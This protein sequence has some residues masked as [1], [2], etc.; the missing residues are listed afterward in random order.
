VSI[1]SLLAPLV[2]QHTALC[3]RC[4]AELSGTSHLDVHRTVM[5]MVRSGE[6]TYKLECRRCGTDDATQLP[7]GLAHG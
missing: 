2:R 3:I 1:E 7:I 4:L 6:F 5:A